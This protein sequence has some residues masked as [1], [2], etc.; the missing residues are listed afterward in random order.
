MDC[1]A[2]A[3]YAMPCCAMLCHAMPCHAMPPCYNPT[4]DGSLTTIDLRTC[5]E[6]HRHMC[7]CWCLYNRTSLLS[8]SCTANLL[9]PFVSACTLY[10]AV[11]TQ[12]YLIGRCAYPL[13][14]YWE[15]HLH[16]E[17][18]LL[19]V[20]PLRQEVCLPS[21]ISSNGSLTQLQLMRRFAYPVALRQAVYLPSCNSL[22]GLLTQSHFVER[23]DYPAAYYWEFC[24]PSC[25][26]Q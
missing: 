19:C 2:M 17:V 14:F 11:L 18:C 4:T 5:C 8:S 15:L 20:A 7:R 22:G 6:Q 3:C 21:Y 25:T 24:L 13:A 12:L 1:H 16:R 23:F 10:R 26:S 9:F